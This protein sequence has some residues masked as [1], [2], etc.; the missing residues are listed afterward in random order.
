[1]NAMLE[2]FRLF[3]NAQLLVEVPILVAR[4][5]TATGILVASLAEVDLRI[6]YATSCLTGAWLR[7]SIGR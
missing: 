3:T 4:E 6:F 1:M 5:R 7:C 2:S